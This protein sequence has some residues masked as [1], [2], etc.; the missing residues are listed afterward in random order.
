MLT[1]IIKI[2]GGQANMTSLNLDTL[3][4][5]TGVFITES[6]FQV[7]ELEY[8]DYLEENQYSDDEYAANN[9]I[10]EW[11]EEQ[12]TL[13]TF[14][15]TSDGNIKYYN[16]EGEVEFKPTTMEFLDNMDM[17]S[18]H[19]ENMC[20]RD[21]QVFKEILET[22]KVDKKLLTNILQEETITHKEIYELL[23]TMKA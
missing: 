12:V 1:L 3:R 15:E 6:D 11:K 5:V 20:R 19:W 13:G 22:G 9:F 10:H 14:T 21:W 17:N 18:Y 4:Q 7:I 23:N 8:K 2:Y 16:P